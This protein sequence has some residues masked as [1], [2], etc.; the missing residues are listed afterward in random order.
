MKFLSEIKHPVTL[1]DLFWDAQK[2]KCLTAGKERLQHNYIQAK[3][4]FPP[5]TLVSVG[6]VPSAVPSLKVLLG[7]R[8]SS[9]CPSDRNLFIP[10]SELPS[11]EY[12]A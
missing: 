1:Q 9:V 2:K 3:K 5:L 12:V 7:T 10:F 8:I 11:V 6:L 4:D